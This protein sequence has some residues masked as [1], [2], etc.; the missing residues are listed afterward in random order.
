[1]ST[2]RPPF[3]TF[4]MPT[5]RGC[6]A[7]GSACGTCEKCA[8]ERKEAGFTL[9]YVAPSKPAAPSLEIMDNQTYET[10]K[11]HPAMKA[12]AIKAL[13]ED[14]LGDNCGSLGRDVEAAGTLTNLRNQVVY[15]QMTIRAAVEDIE[16]QDVGSACRRL[17]ISLDRTNH[18]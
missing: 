13:I 5:C 11:W 16:D 15:L 2:Q 4:K 6:Y 1:M 18:E 7:L 10:W 17:R 8:W 12:E 9:D 14:F 3:E